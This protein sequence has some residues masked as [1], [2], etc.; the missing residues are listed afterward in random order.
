MSERTLKANN[1]IKLAWEK[2]QKLVQQGKGTRDWTPEQQKD[3]LEY[4]KAYDEKG[5]AFEGQHMKSVEKYPEFQGEPEN[6]QFLTRQEHLEA[7][8]GNWKSSTN[9]RY[10]PVTKEYLDFGEEKYIPCPVIELSNP[11][12]KIPD[13][14]AD[15]SKNDELSEKLNTSKTRE[16]QIPSKKKENDLIKNKK[17]IFTE[18]NIKIKSSGVENLK[19]TSPK[20][21]GFTDVLKLMRKDIVAHPFKFIKAVSPVIG[22]A[23]GFATNRIMK[24]KIDRYN[25]D[26]YSF[27]Q[28][29]PD[30][31]SEKK[32]PESNRMNQV[33]RHTPGENDVPAHKQ[34]YHTK[35]KGVIW[36]NKEPYTR[37]KK[38]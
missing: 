1:A 37:G 13:I 4:G 32:M 9:W 31:V 33:N 24:K 35:E 12:V 15:S 20:E 18:K 19:R 25:S 6:I 22:G 27:Q 29:A 2:E 38:E 7:H 36:K 14:I 8:H 34:R 30:T 26:F 23:I 17:Y 21:F 5:N 10:N 16:T 11:I 28:S 3:I